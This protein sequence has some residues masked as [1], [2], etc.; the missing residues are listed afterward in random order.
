MKA[1][2]KLSYSSSRRTPGSS[3]LV[4]LDPIAGFRSSG[5]TL[6]LILLHEVEQP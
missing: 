3:A 1:E 6:L 4:L 5:M 2:K